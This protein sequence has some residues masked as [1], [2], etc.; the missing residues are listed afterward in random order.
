M[1]RVS[2]DVGTDGRAW[3]FGQRA[4][5]RAEQRARSRKDGAALV[6][7]VVRLVPFC[8]MVSQSQGSEGSYTTGGGEE[9]V[10]R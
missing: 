1:R 7:L 5:E 6:R 8:H 9:A 3:R 4:Y 10:A 2:T